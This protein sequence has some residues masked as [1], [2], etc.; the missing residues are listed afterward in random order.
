MK[1]V[2]SLKQADASEACLGSHSF[3]HPLSSPEAT[4]PSATGSRTLMAASCAC[5]CHFFTLQVATSIAFITLHSARGGGGLE[6]AQLQASG[7]AYA[8]GGCYG[9]NV[10]EKL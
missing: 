5:G 1:S 10:L 4:R 3:T 8:A 7:P 9:E 6:E 2:C